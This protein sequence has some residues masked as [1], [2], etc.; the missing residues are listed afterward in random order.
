MTELL[1]PPEIASGVRVSIGKSYLLAAAFHLHIRGS[2]IPTTSAST[3]T[4]TA[5]ST[6]SIRVPTP[7]LR[8]L[9]HSK[10][11]QFRVNTQRY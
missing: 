6:S 9:V 7:S 4:A 3:R 1:G 10:K 5:V 2:T 8:L 11:E